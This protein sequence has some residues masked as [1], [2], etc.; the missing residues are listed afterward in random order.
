ME[1][2]VNYFPYQMLVQKMVSQMR[3]VGMFSIVVGALNCLTI[4][5]CVI[6][7]PIIMAGSRL[8]ESADYFLHYLSTNDNYILQKAFEK[9]ER[10][11][12]IMKVLIIIG[13]I[14]FI[15]SIFIYILLI[16]L[17]ISRVKGFDYTALL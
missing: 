13:L 4:F 5:G 7:I 17:I 3:F 11:F 1:D 10:Y 6:G 14:I 2:N 9:L 8:R 15:I 16:G 12:F